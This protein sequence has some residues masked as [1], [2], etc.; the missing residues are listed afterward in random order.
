MS[1]AD[2]VRWEERWHERPP[3]GA[4]PEP[5]LLREASLLPPRGRVLDVA[6]GD[7]R[8]SLWL[9]RQ[10]FKVTAVDVAP[11]AIARLEAAARAQGL[12]VTARQA[13]LDDPGALSD[14]AP[15][16]AMVVIR[17][18]PSADQWA[19]LL[20]R[21]R[22]GG[23]LLLCSFSRAQHERHAFPLAYCLD[24]AALSAELTPALRLLRWSGF[25]EDGAF[26]AGSLWER[27]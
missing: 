5:F 23:R 10:G 19:A 16:D 9:A 4:A 6:A 25:E 17:F 24:Q 20:D 11:T 1:A 2:L 7:G 22:P 21:L 14:H 26:L 8:N 13:D 12:H 3:G 27:A 18:R 15:F